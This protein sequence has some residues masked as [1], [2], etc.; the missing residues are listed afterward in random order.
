MNRPVNGGISARSMAEAILPIEAA[1]RAAKDSGRYLLWLDETEAKLFREPGWLK[2]E[3]AR[4]GRVSFVHPQREIRAA[5]KRG[6]L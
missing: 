3:P 1:R 5:R 2:L 4:D 6:I